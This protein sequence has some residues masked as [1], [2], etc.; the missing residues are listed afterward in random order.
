MIRMEW[1]EYLVRLRFHVDGFYAEKLTREYVEREVR[2]KLS[3]PELE[4][5]GLMEII[6][7][8]TG[9]DGLLN[10]PVKRGELWVRELEDGRFA[11]NLDDPK[12]TCVEVQV[13][14]EDLE[15]ETIKAKGVKYVIIG[16]VPDTWG[17]LDS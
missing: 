4:E 14:R 16:D 7:S 11:I 2:R 15:E 6:V 8:E 9:V 12:I 10:I 1:V 3:I 17:R 5:E 13:V